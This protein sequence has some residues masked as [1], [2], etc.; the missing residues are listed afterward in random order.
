[1]TGRIRKALKSKLSGVTVIYYR[2]EGIAPEQVRGMLPS[3][4]EFKN[5][6]PESFKILLGKLEGK[7]IIPLKIFDVRSEERVI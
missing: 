7:N 5:P 2:L 3:A 6:T 1:M 4:L